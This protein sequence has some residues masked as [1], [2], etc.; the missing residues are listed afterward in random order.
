MRVG[1]RKQTGARVSGCV[2]GCLSACVGTCVD[3]RVN[4]GESN[5]FDGG[6]ILRDFLL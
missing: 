3:K 1:R 4:G 2:R 6:R 5:L